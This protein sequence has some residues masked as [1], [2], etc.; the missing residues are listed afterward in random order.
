MA[1]IMDSFMHE[2]ISQWHDVHMHI[3]EFI[4]VQSNLKLKTKL[5]T[6]Y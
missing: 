6:S 3:H 4:I 5:I 1:I 2:N